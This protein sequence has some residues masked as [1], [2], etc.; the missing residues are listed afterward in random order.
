MRFSD[1]VLCWYMTLRSSTYRTGQGTQIRRYTS[2]A[3]LQEAETVLSDCQIHIREKLFRKISM[4][5]WLEIIK[6]I[7]AGEVVWNKQSKHYWNNGRIF[8]YSD[9]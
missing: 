6:N 2:L 9:I 1:L 8:V 3:R 5:R 7:Q 4:L